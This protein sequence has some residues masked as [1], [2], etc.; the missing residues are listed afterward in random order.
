[1][2]LPAGIRRI[3]DQ[4]WDGFL[5]AEPLAG[6]EIGDPRFDDRLPDPGPEGLARRRELFERGLAALADVAPAGL[7]Q[8]ARTTLAVL[9]TIARNGLSALAHRLD[10]FE[11]VSHL[12]G[13]G[14]ML[15][16]LATL[17]QAA[18]TEQAERYVARLRAIPAW[19]GSICGVL[20]E[21]IAAGATAPGL[22]VDRTIVQIDRL[23]ALAPEASPGMA[24]LPGDSPVRDEVAA[25]L[26]DEVWP[27]YVRYAEELRAYRPHARASIGL[28]DL[29]GGEEA[30]ATLIA[31]HTTL[32]ADAA[33]VHELGQREL[34]IVQEE[35]Q[36]VV[37]EMGFASA[38]EAIA[39]YTAFGADTATTG[40]ELLDLVRDQVRRSWEAAPRFFGRLP[41]AACAVKPVEEFREQDMPPAFYYPPAGD[42]SRPGIYYVNLGD[43]PQRQLHTMAAI[44]FHEANP[45]H[46]FQ[47]SLD[48]EHPGRHP[49]RRFG[50]AWASTAFVEGWGLYSERLADEMGLYTTP[51]ERLGMLAAQ[52]WRAARLV[53]DTGI[54]AFGWDRQRAVD[55][56]ASAGVPRH[57]AEGEIDRYITMPGQA[58]AYKVGQIEIERWR[59]EAEARQPGFS[60]AAFHDRLLE[61]GSLPLPVVERELG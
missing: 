5:E 56:L 60:L 42:G 31:Q 22:V 41:A 33:A 39:A 9:E 35:E 17:Q 50:G 55:L 25:I 4:F 53:V 14:Q 43:L 28:C 15:P 37:G 46:H 18:T 19:L 20:R 38:A 44:S 6:T 16:T 58:L 8:E 13:P 29:P 47:L 45:G 1:M 30:Y 23:L 7:D 3:A 34:A 32:A 49:L 26:R 61:L 51:H 11:A 59:R 57:V 2:P 40:E 12:T 54:H 52:G 10:R 24:P 27:A 48:M 21:G 36:A